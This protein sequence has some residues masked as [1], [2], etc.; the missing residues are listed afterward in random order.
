M[1]NHRQRRGRKAT[2]S[3]ARVQCTAEAIRTDGSY[4]HLSKDIDEN[5]FYMWA[6]NVDWDLAGKEAAVRIDFYDDKGQLSYASLS[7]FSKDNKSP[8]IPISKPKA[9]LERFM[10]STWI[11]ITPKH[12]SKFKFPIDKPF[13]IVDEI[14]KCIDAWQMTK[15]DHSASS[16]EVDHSADGAEV[17]LGSKLP[18]GSKGGTDATVLSKSGI[19]TE[20][21]V[22]KVAIT[23]DD[24][25][26]TAR[27]RKA[28]QR[29]SACQKWTNTLEP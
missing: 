17:K 22:I 21:A 16:A 27:S 5:L 19:N 14:G 1:L 25:A 4:V 15:G 10:L 26:N 9:F 8:D 12:G 7:A 23:R 20:N 11:Q 3:A 18:Y 13:E 24:A 6:R 2:A 29:G 28:G